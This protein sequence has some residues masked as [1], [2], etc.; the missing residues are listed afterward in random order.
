MLY[1]YLE[2]QL[3]KHIEL[4]FFG[5]N[6]KVNLLNI[7]FQFWMRQRHC[8]I[9]SNETLWNSHH[10]EVKLMSRIFLSWKTVVS[11]A[12]QYK[13]NCVDAG[14]YFPEIWFHSHSLLWRAKA[15]FHSSICRGLQSLRGQWTTVPVEFTLNIRCHES[16]GL[17]LAF[18]SGHLRI[19]CYWENIAADVFQGFGW[20]SKVYLS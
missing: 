20:H 2:S 15:A 10:I 14:S 3:R 13:I 8:S 17:T 1:S 11:F 18:S 6:R 9:I 4:I 7:Q 19:R 5:R 12:F 16:S